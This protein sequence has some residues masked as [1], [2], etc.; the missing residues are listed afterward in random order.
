MEKPTII[1]FIPARSGSKRIKDKNI[2]P[3]GGHPLIA[4]SIVSALESEIFSHVMVSTDSEKYAQIARYYGAE[5]P[6]LRPVEYT[7]A[8]SPDIEWMRYT[9]KKL[10][11]EGEVYDCFAILRPT[12]PFRK[13]ETIQ[14]AWQQF[15]ADGKADSLRA[16]E[17]CSQH[18]A[19]MWIVDKK[20]NRMEPVMKNPNPTGTPWHSQ[21]YLSLP[22][23]FVQNASLEIAWTR[24]VIKENS[25]SGKNIM[26][27]FTQGDEGVDV[28][29][30]YD[31]YYAEKLLQEE[32]A[33]LPEI[34]IRPY[35]IKS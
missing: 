11:E 35:V 29:T 12:S 9:L 21:Q 31:W 18:P 20:K 13:A 19:K 32:K 27:F 22:E 8:T 2:R 17:K 7:S 5:V 28:N 23:V 26:P 33:K 30:E 10:K 15:L 16:V 3:L 34:K 6:F 24:C 14:R 25:I 4:Y 1:G